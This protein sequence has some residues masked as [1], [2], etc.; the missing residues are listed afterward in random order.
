MIARW[1]RTSEQRAIARCR[2]FRHD[3]DGHVFVENGLWVARLQCQRCGTKRVDKM[4]PKTCE[5][6][7]RVYDWPDEY[8][9]TIDRE[10]VRRELLAAMRTKGTH[11]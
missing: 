8:D 3:F 2:I 9:R 11:E 7:G 4:T 10:Q 6:I 1:L 5:L